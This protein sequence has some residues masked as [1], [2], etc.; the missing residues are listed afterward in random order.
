[1]LG[2]AGSGKTTLAILRAAYLADS[3]TP[4][5]GTTLLVTF[6]RA[7]VTYLQ[8]LAA[9]ELRNVHVENYHVFA[10]G[11]INSRGLMSYNCICDPE[12]RDSL[13]SGAVASLANGSVEN[14]AGRPKS[15]FSEAVRW[16]Y[17]LGL[18]EESGAIT[19]L[20]HGLGLTEAE[21]N[22][23]WRVRVTYEQLR[24]QVG[25]LYDWD[26]I[27]ITVNSE[28]TVD[29]RP[30]LYRHVV[31]DE[32]QD[33]SPVMI[34]SLTRAVGDEGAVTF[35][36]DVAQQI[37]GNK[38]SWRSAGLE[39]TEPWLFEENYRNTKQIADLALALTRQPFYAGMA[40][41]V[42]PRS[43][44]AAGPLPALVRCTNS[45][46]ECD[47]MLQ[48]ALK[49][50][51]EGTAA[52]LVRDREDERLFTSRLRANSFIRLHREMTIWQPESGL[53]IGTYH[54]AKGLEFDAV[55]LPFL[56]AERM[57]DPDVVE[58]NG[59]ADGDAMEARLLYVGITRARS[60]L[61]LSYHGTLTRLLPSETSLYQSVSA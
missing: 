60:T 25:K 36:G 46:K 31:I 42:S 56:S 8:H 12:T 29:D 51:R 2:T 58:I 14:L 4:H 45:A 7:L 47:F 54:A 18:V 41:L 17:Q 39:I 50:S 28:L 16:T 23:V 37:Y 15:F 13:I 61:V 10:R 32:G 5:A 24:Q 40:D 49:A 26:D 6:N 35:F 19:G 21:A 11:Y 43:P 44:R 59:E 48:A 53:Y 57:P 22:S 3:A 27:A 52:I 9:P 20:Q 55:Y 1:M 34:Q 33:F 38:F 30:R